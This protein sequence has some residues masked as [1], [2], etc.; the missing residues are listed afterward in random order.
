MQMAA[1]VCSS[2]APVEGSVGSSTARKGVWQ[3]Q[4]KAS[5]HSPLQTTVRNLS[6]LTDMTDFLM[7]NP[8]AMLMDSPLVGRQ[9]SHLPGGVMGTSAASEPVYGNPFL[10]IPKNQ[11]GF[12]LL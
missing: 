5:K 12:G 1:R 11:A 4:P 2:Y 10:K 9:L 6:P 3:C 8:F 7:D